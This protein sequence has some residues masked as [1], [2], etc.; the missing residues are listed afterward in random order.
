MIYLKS[1]ME[2]YKTNF[3]VVYRLAGL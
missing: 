1:V 3:I 2:V